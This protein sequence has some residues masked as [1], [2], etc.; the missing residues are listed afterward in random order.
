[1]SV[2]VIEIAQV[3]IANRGSA[4]ENESQL[5]VRRSRI[6][7]RMTS[8]LGLLCGTVALLGVAACGARLAPARTPAADDPSSARDRDLLDVTVQQLQRYYADRRYTVTQVVEWHLDRVDRYN[9]IYRAIEDVF[10]GE[11]LK[12][13]AELDAEKLASGKTGRGPLWGVPV[14]I[15]A[16]TSVRDYVTTD[17]WEGFT[18]PLHELIAPQDATVVSR[19]HAA[20]A[21]IIGHTN[22]PD[23]AN[24]D[25][26]RS[27]S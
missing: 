8:R 5:W 23:F 2:Q 6:A 14:V 21:V 25:T 27:T 3:R 16:N 26:N 24:S 13:A 12:R 9:S 19:L 1:V 22:M 15:K 7:A 18:I 17:G 20:G 10:R 4:V 11:A